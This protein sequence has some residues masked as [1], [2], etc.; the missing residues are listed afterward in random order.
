MQ[1]QI[2]SLI[3]FSALGTL[4]VGCNEKISPKL[5]GANSSTVVPG[6]VVPDEYYFKVVNDS[7]KILNYVLHRTGPGNKTA[8][9]NIKSSSAFSSDNFIAEA[10]RAHDSKIYDI[11][12]MMEAEEFALYFNGLD[13]K[14]ES[15][16]NTCAY[17]GYTPYGFYESIPG[18]SSAKYYRL[19]C[20]DTVTSPTAATYLALNLAPADL[21]FFQANNV[22]I[23]CGKM[24]DVTTPDNLR[25]PFDGDSELPDLCRFDYSDN[26]SG[27]K[28]N[29]DV[30]KIETTTLTLLDTNDNGTVDG[31]ELSDPEKSSCG[32]KISAC[33]GGPSKVMFPNGTRGTEFANSVTDQPFSQKYSLPSLITK[34]RI[35]SYEISNY[36]KGLAHQSIPYINYDSAN[37]GH[38]QSDSNNRSF[39]PMLMERYAANLLYDGSTQVVDEDYTA[40]GVLNDFVYEYGHTTIPY[41]VEPFVGLYNMRVNPFYTF[42]CYDNA[43]EARA[44]IRMVVRDWDRVF[45]T[46]NQYNEYLSDIFLGIKARQELPTQQEVLGDPAPYTAFNDKLDWDNFIPMQRSALGVYAPDEVYVRPLWGAAGGN[47]FLNYKFFTQMGDTDNED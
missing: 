37:S 5:E 35:G 14:V 21:D 31:F 13:F 11:T 23:N 26:E 10:A 9:C 12:C 25:L 36:R 46:S 28:Q 20:P 15:S 38:W 45:T 44:R 34:Q 33:V 30:G 6:S 18:D 7:P 16:A 29:C 43:L 3:F 42:T 17:I 24:V 19:E 22:T 2:Y 32:G 41:A 1:R 47:S 39:N 27:F 4:A 40:P 8:A